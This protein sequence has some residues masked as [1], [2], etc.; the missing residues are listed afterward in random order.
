MSYELG[1]LPEFIEGITGGIGVL[2]DIKQAFEKG[3]WFDG[4]LCL[5][6]RFVASDMHLNAT[7]QEIHADADGKYNLPGD[8]DHTAA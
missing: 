7:G 1:V 2:E 3:D 5:V 6:I 8:L 4:N